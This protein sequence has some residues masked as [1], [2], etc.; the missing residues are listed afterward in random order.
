[1]KS[2]KSKSNTRTMSTRSNVGKKNE[3]KE[4]NPFFAF[5]APAALLSAFVK[6]HGDRAK[7]CAAIRA[8]MSKATGVKVEEV[9]HAE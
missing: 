9:A 1:M 8:H 5:R 7:A 6:K 3:R 4:G 2:K